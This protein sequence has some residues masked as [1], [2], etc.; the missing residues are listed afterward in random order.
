MVRLIANRVALA[1]GLALLVI[2]VALVWVPAAFIVAGLTVG[3]G[4]I[5]AIGGEQ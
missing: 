5:I 2:G 4:A 1:A 3:A